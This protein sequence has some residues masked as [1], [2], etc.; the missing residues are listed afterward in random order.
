MAPVSPVNFKFN[1]KDSLSLDLSWSGDTKPWVNLLKKAARI[2]QGG[3]LLFI[4]PTSYKLGMIVGAA[5]GAHAWINNKR[6][7]DNFHIGASVGNFVRETTPLERI[8]VVAGLVGLTGYAVKKIAPFV[9][10]IGAIGIGL[11]QGHSDGVACLNASREVLSDAWANRPAALRNENKNSGYRVPQQPKPQEQPKN[12]NIVVPQELNAQKSTAPKWLNDESTV[13]WID[14]QGVPF[15]LKDEDNAEAH[16]FDGVEWRVPLFP[17]HQ[18]VADNG[19]DYFSAAPWKWTGVDGLQREQVLN[20]EVQV[21]YNGKR[22]QAT[23]VKEH[24]AVGKFTGG[25]KNV[26]LM[27][28]VGNDT[29]LFA[30]GK[31]HRQ[32]A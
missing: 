16:Q 11:R 5:R 19:P 4:A 23:E 15:V 8:P 26:P 14:D 27:A 3:A 12:G 24:T 13:R 28:Q 29:L 18:Y 1:W 7:E 22:Y 32:V 25:A 2:A 9:Y 10:N 6:V 30:A 21:I 20:G 17:A 31:W